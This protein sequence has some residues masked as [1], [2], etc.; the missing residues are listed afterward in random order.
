MKKFQS[1]GCSLTEIKEILQEQDTNV[2][3]NQQV[4]EW[5]HNKIKETERKKDEYDQ[6]P[7]TLSWMLEYKA[8]LE[9][10]PENHILCGRPGIP[11]GKV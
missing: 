3:S 1:V 8:A 4:I 6:T 9:N 5:I 2:I 10:D 7:D 11:M